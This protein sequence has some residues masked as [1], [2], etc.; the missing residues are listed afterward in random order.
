VTSPPMMFLLALAVATL[1]RD[2]PPSQSVAMTLSQEK[3]GYDALNKMMDNV[4]SI[5]AKTKA[6][7]AAMEKT[8]FFKLPAKPSSLLESSSPGS[9]L[10]RFD[11]EREEKDLAELGRKFQA[12]LASIHGVKPS[13]LLETDGS[14][15]TEL[16]DDMATVHKE[17]KQFSDLRDAAQKRV[18]D[19]K[20]WAEKMHAEFKT[21]E[22]AEK[23]SMQGPKA[24]AFAAG[25]PSSFVQVNAEGKI[26]PIPIPDV[27]LFDPSKKYDVAAMK[28]TVEEDQDAVSDA[29]QR[30]EDAMDSWKSD[31]LQKL[32]FDDDAS[33]SSFMETG[34]GVSTEHKV[35]AM[36]R[37]L[38]KLRKFVGTPFFKAV[39]NYAAKPTSALLENGHSSNEIA[40]MRGLVH[41]LGKVPEMT[42][43]D[44]DLGEAQARLTKVQSQVDS[45]MANLDK[46]LQAQAK[47][48][49][50]S[51]SSFLEEGHPKF[52]FHESADLIAENEDLLKTK[53]ITSELHKK[54]LAAREKLQE[55]FKHMVGK[56]HHTKAFTEL[57][58]HPH[59]L[60]SLMQKKRKGDDGEEE[61]DAPEQDD[62]PAQDDEDSEPEEVK[63]EDPA[64]DSSFAQTT[65]KEMRTH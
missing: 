48:E 52:K 49:G 5:Q 12:Q 28:A 24:A 29:K 21:E 34:S 61:T 14:D 26:A 27:G 36:E 54:T 57:L 17:M 30:F 2:E 55:D 64:E 19:V 46:K 56:F 65:T 15:D 44:S 35:V 63:D 38:H 9:N 60:S 3:R 37:H 59:H 25:K 22:A 45:E 7:L 33:P 31:K 6:E 13:S 8:D 32:T 41:A 58:E 23:A 18:G 51:A 40:D 4:Q 43:M 47:K 11:A 20:Q 50:I 53:A 16:N 1:K 39:E 10:H 42:N 62:A